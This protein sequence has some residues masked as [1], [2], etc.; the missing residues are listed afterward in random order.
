MTEENEGKY[1]TNFNWNENEHHWKNQGE[2]KKVQEEVT[3]RYEFKGKNNRI[4]P[5][6]EWGEQSWV[7]TGCNFGCIHFKEK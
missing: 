3:D 1:R 6:S 7:V 4:T 5:V 2:C